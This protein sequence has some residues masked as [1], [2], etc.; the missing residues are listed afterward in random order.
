MWGAQ[1]LRSVAVYGVSGVWGYIGSQECKD[2]QGL[3]SA[4]IEDLRTVG[5]TGSQ[6]W[7]TEVL[8][9][10]VSELSFQFSC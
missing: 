4:G 8:R 2:I 5:Y 7:G 10:V 6:E 3:R 1:G 9:T